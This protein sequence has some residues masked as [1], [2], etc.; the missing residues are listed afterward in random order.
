MTVYNDQVSAYI[1][2]L[3]AAEDQALQHVRTSSLQQGLPGIEIKAEEGRFLQFLVRACGV[4]KAVE[5]GTLGGY[6]GTWIAR[7]LLPGGK[8]ITLELEPRHAA[9]AQQ[10]FQVAGVAGQVEILTD[11]SY[12]HGV[13]VKGWKAKANQAVATVRSNTR[14]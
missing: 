8:L 11:S 2:Q 10:H 14:S 5:I 9:V 12:S 7:G 3:F 1:T 6:S 13:L 4:R